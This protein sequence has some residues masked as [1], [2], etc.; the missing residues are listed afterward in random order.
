MFLLRRAPRT[1]HLALRTMLSIVVP[2][3]VGYATGH[4][5][6]GLL[7]AVGGFASLFGGGRPYA[8]RTRL[9]VLVSLGEALAVALGIWA[10]EVPWAGVLVVTLIAVVAT[11][12][13]NAFAVVPGAYQFAL[14]CATGTALHAESADPVQ[15]GLLV[16]AGGLFATLL[17]L[18]GA[19]VDR[20][21]PERQ[22]VA[23]AA[24]AVADFVDA[25]GG[26]GSDELQHAAALAMQQAWTVLVAEQPVA[27][28]SGRARPPEGLL[29]LREISRTL[30]LVLAD[31]LRRGTPDP[32]AAGRARQLGWQARRRRGPRQ[33]GVLFA[34]PLGRP[35][36]G[37]VLLTALEPGSRSFL[38]LVRVAVASLVSGVLA[39][40]LGL[41]HAYWA[42]ATS[43][44]VLATGFDQRRT[45]QRGLERSAGTVLGVG[46]V[47]L[48][49][50]A[51]P[52]GPVL[53]AVVAVVVYGA[54][55]LV[56]RNYAAAAV[57]ITCSALL[58]GVAGSTQDAGELLLARALDTLIG[59]GVALSVFALVSRK[60]PA[61]WLPD[62]L[63]AALEAAADAVD[64][65]T[66]DRVVSPAGLRA[67]RDLE[68][69]V[70][71]LRETSTNNLNGFP[72]QRDAAERLW[73]VVVAGERLAYRVLAE[74]YRLEES[75]G[76]EGSAE[77]RARL[78]DAGPPPSE[79][80]RR[81]ATRIRH[82]GPATGLG[83]VPSFVSRDVGD[84][85]RVLL[86]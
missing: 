77:G 64:Q 29:R 59:A 78:T 61:A 16:L 51:D 62:A 39:S 11:W 84:L 66:P 1:W 30:Q 75:G 56:P 73:P 38:V 55:L 21:G 82:G 71:R 15:S 47:A 52:V 48:V 43:V 69:S 58:M 83:D 42:V 3:S 26:P 67:R 36:P 31:A 23:H 46:A 50:R 34:L 40:A 6:L 32:G 54:Q 80:L 25:V 22:A 10:E 4:L 17:Q 8:Y 9:L 19:L 37:R 41:S 14:C 45:V 79:G 68:R 13:C 20:H 2:A 24:D 33:R 57:L 12:I 65:L 35:H 44:L 53:V 60:T 81:L 27:S 70:T 86:V 85:R 72:A 63:A 76:R 49:L 7:V 5:S 18:T 74:A 28:R